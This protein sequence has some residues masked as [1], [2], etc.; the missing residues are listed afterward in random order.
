MAL[1]VPRKGLALA[2]PIAQARSPAA[3]LWQRKGLAL[4]APIAQA[5]PPAAPAWQR[6]GLALAVPRALVRRPGAAERDVA[7]A[8]ALAGVLAIAAAG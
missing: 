1:G 3:P 5:R 6:E 7:A 2:A 4:A 8:Q